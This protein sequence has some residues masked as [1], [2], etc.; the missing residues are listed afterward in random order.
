MREYVSLVA[1]LLA[2]PFGVFFVVQGVTTT[3]FVGIVGLFADTLPLVAHALVLIAFGLVL[4]G[5]GIW[6]LYGALRDFPHLCARTRRV[7]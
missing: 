5:V 3:G 2:V 7:G 1:R 6:L 4:V